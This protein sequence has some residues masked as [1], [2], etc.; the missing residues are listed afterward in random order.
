MGHSKGT[1]PVPVGA[2]LGQKA[3]Y[4]HSMAR[5]NIGTVWAQLGANTILVYNFSVHVIGLNSLQHGHVV[6]GMKIASLKAMAGWGIFD[7][8]A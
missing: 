4:V 7:F 3:Q 1:F 5:F 6:R 2:Q 8:M